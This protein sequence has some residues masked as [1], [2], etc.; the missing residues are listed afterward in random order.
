MDMDFEETD[1]A[2]LDYQLDGFLTEGADLTQTMVD[3][4]DDMDVNMEMF[5]TKEEKSQNQSAVQTSMSDSSCTYRSVGLP[6][7]KDPTNQSLASPPLLPP[8]GEVANLIISPIQTNVTETD[9]QPDDQ[10]DGLGPNEKSYA[11]ANL[12]EQ[13]TSVDE[14]QGTQR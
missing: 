3:P 11:A 5:E 1:D 10:V 8:G 12:D 4:F 6:I 7:Q 13:E 2:F 9:H 14:E